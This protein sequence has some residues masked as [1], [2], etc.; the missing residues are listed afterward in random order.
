MMQAKIFTTYSHNEE[1]MEK[2][3]NEFL[4]EVKP[5]KV[6]IIQSQSATSNGGSYLIL[7]M[8]YY[9]D[10]VHEPERVPNED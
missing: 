10:E 6:E 1:M 4:A 9:V 5:S 3:I 2:R 7:T 8:L